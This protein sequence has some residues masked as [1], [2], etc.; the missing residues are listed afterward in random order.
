MRV[1]G[2]VIGGVLL[3][4]VLQTANPASAAEAGAARIEHKIVA[5]E[6][7]VWGPAPPGLPPGSKA[8][9]LSGNPAEAGPFT[10]RAWLPKGYKVPPHWH[11]TVENLTVL[12]GRLHLGMGDTW[13]LSKATEIRAGAFA[14]LPPEM[15]HWLST[16]E[17]TVL[18]VHGEGPF[19][20]V[21]VN[22]DDDPRKPAK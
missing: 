5:S 9:V 7:I 19:M 12:S 11:S 13:D 15:R 10:L 4:G 17:D 14:A 3:L 6:T 18:Q 22:P 16:D 8:A 2:S 1:L 21:Y 20:I